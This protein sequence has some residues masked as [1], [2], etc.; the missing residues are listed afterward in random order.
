MLPLEG[1]QMYPS[2]KG[3]VLKRNSSRQRS[4]KFKY[5]RIVVTHILWNVSNVA[6]KKVIADT[7]PISL[8]S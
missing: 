2:I 1:F 5:S 6:T 4:G 3:Q 7:C 8:G